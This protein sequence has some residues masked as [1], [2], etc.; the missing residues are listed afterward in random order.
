MED[1]AVAVNTEDQPAVET[2]NHRE[3]TG[4][5]VAQLEGVHFDYTMLG[6]GGSKKISGVETRIGGHIQVK[7]R[8]IEVAAL[9]GIDL[10]IRAGQRIGFC[11]SNGAG[12]STLLR[13]IAGIY[14]PT[15]GTI[16]VQGKIASIFDRMLGMDS[17]LTGHENILIRGMFMGMKPEAVR[18]KI[19]E[20][21]DFCELDDFLHLPLRAYSP[22]MRARLGFAICTAFDA[23]ILLLDEWLGVGDARFAE[24][25]RER[26][27]EFFGSAGTV[28]L[29]SQNEKLIKN[30]CHEYFQLEKGRIVDHVIL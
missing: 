21:V 23:D 27:G 12:K 22:G 18:E 20:I 9:Q 24:R 25:A 5:V 26:M 11:G 7:K 30:N 29:A 4:R 8:R 17:E 2:Q 1:P 3:Q 28:I 15:Q 13:L 6:V 10:E 19:D 16:Q 14:K